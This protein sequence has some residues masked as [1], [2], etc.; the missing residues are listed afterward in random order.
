VPYE[1]VIYEPG[2]VARV[3]L[4][5][6]Q[7]QNA[8]IWRLLSEMDHAFNTVCADPAVRIIVLSGNGPSFSPGHDLDSP[9]HLKDQEQRNRE[10]DDCLVWRHDLLSCI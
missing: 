4:N 7:R 5:R 3:I 10:I 9:E 1:A 6:P 2:P 8:Q